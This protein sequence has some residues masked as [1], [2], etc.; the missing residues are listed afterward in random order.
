MRENQQENAISLIETVSEKDQLEANIYKARIY[1][2]KGDFLTALKIANNCIKRAK[3]RNNKTMEVIARIAKV[4]SLFRTEQYEIGLTFALETESLYESLHK[5]GRE[6]IQD[7][8]GMLY[9]L[10]GSFYNY[11]GDL[12]FAL[13]YYKLALKVR[14]ELDDK[15]DIAKSLN[16]IGE[17]YRSKGELDLA[18]DYYLQSLKH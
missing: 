8:G 1:N 13:K 10:I 4:T 6:Y 7:W 17:I 2:S 9:N 15:T 16:N 12:N 11:G 5:K 14:K 3:R 18:L